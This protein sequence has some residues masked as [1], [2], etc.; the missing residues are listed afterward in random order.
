M[1]SPQDPV[2]LAN[3]GL[4]LLISFCVA[5]MLVGLLV[6]RSRFWADKNGSHKTVGRLMILCGG[7]VAFVALLFLISNLTKL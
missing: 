2:N 1:I 6:M 4:L 5:L 3:V 7:I